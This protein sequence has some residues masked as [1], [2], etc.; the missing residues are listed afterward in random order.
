MSGTTERPSVEQSAQTQISDLVVGHMHAYT[1][2]GP[3]RARTTID[4]DL[5]TVVL[6]DLLNKG[7]HSL[8]SDGR[9]QLVLDT[10]QAFQQTMRDDLILGVERV[11]G[12]TVIAF[13]SANHLDPDIAIES[14]VL[15]S[16]DETS[17]SADHA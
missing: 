15:Q 17:D 7:E 12:R 14:F 4:R 9:G 8:I 10:R 3:T 2:R 16:R 6:R 5:V 1:G 13:M 11:T